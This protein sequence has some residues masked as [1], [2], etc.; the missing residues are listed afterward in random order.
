[1][2]NEELRSYVNTLTTLNPQPSSI[3]HYPLSIIHYQLSIINPPMF[4]IISLTKSRLARHY[5][6]EASAVVATNHLMRWVHGCPP[7]M[8]ELEAV[9]YCRSQKWLTARQV[10]LIVRHLG[11]P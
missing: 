6:P 5:F 7:L 1:M 3:I 4:Q 10:A 11:E 2:K 9:G 8:E